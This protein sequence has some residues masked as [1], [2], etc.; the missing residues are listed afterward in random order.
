M[1]DL[2]KAICAAALTGMLVGAA[3]VATR[4]VSADATAETLAFLRYAIGPAFL[5]PPVLRRWS[6]HF[7]AKDFF[8]VAGLGI[9]QFAILMLPMN[10]AFAKR[11]AVWIK[12]GLRARRQGPNKSSYSK[13]RARPLRPTHGHI[14]IFSCRRMAREH[15]MPS[16]H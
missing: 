10:Y 6:V 9:L 11:A 4:T 5:V 14:R 12:N 13:T 8:A 16:W 7:P 2:A 1:S 15:P 3:M